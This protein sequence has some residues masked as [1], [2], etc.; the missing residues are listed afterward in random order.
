MHL[1]FIVNPAAGAGLALRRWQAF[2]SQLKT[3]GILSQHVF[4]HRA[5][6]AI[7]LARDSCIN[8]DLL[9]AV[10]GDGTVTEVSQGILTSPVSRASLGIVPFGTGNDVA[11]ALGISNQVQALTSLTSGHSKTIDVL[12]VSCYVNG[13][14]TIRHALLFAGVG[15]ISDALRKTT[16]LI[17]RIF[18]QRKAY[19][20]GLLRA[21]AAYHPPRIHLSNDGNPLSGRFL[22]VGASNTPIAGGGMKIAPGA[23]TDDGLMNLNL[24]E[25][26]GPFEALR[27]LHRLCR[28]RHT[29]HPKVLYRTAHCLSIDSPAL[30]VA[31]DGEII[32]QTPVQVHV[33][34]SALRVAVL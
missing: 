5:G 26:C 24:V 19:P 9:V 10:G 20:A 31:A 34:P 17:K 32:G 30:E 12:E 11:Q 15:I 2:N 14:S 13:Q 27:L 23:A 6:E 33:K 18:G 16:P 1:L 25:A 28:G 3:R 22:F 29:D 8:Y 4:T 21:L 7:Q